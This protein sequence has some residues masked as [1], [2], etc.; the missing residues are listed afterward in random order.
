[1][2]NKLILVVEDSPTEKMI[3]V[4]ACEQAGYRVITAGDG[5]EALQMTLDNRPDLILL[6]VILPKK[7]GFQICRQIK[8]TPDIQQTKIIMVTSK[9]QDS[10]R[11][12]G[13]KQG[14]DDYLTKPYAE[15]E[16]LDLISKHLQA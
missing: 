6:D 3:A 5:E 10:D 15:S 13:I 4:T 8:S 11:F 2:S 12:W 9:S 16:L 7:N 1:M 14:A